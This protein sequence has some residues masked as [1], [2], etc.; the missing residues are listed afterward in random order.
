MAARVLAVIVALLLNLTDAFVP[1]RPSLIAS[2]LGSSATDYDV[3]IADCKVILNKAA[4]TKSEDPDQVIAALESLEKLMRLKVKTEGEAASQQVL[5][6]LDGHWR[7]IFTTGTAKTQE[8]LG[9]V[10]Y[11]PLKAVQSFDTQ[12]MT[13]SN[14]IYAGDFSLIKF[15]GNFDFDLKKKKLE[16]DFSLITLLG[17]LNIPL[18]RGDAA[19][20]GAKSGLGSSSNVENAKRDKQAFFNWISADEAIATARGGGG[21]LALWQRTVDPALK[22]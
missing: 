1:P 18:K 22:R 9:R 17:F 20:L 19:Q 7:L 16:F 2:S 11:F 3:K 8:K 10:N 14:G 12:N 13:I 15:F 21:G 4:D 6:N 5:S